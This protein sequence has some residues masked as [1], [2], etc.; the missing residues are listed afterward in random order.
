M[1]RVARLRAERDAVEVVA[2]QAV[3]RLGSLDLKLRL[4]QV[5]QRPAPGR[6]I[7]LSR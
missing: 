6:A 4:E 7:G 5:A 2:P 1:L 3:D